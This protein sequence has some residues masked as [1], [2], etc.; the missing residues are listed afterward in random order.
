M[1]KW[2]KEILENLKGNESTIVDIYRNPKSSYANITM[3]NGHKAQVYK[4]QLIKARV[5]IGDTVIYDLEKAVMSH[6]E[7][8]SFNTNNFK[9]IKMKGEGKAIGALRGIRLEQLAFFDI[10][11]SREHLKL[12]KSKHEQEFNLFQ[13]KIR[14]WPDI[15]SEDTNTVK[16]LYEE[17]ANFF[18]EFSKLVCISM[19]ILDKEQNLKVVSLF[20][21]DEKSILEDLATKLE[22]MHKS[23][24]KYMLAGYSINSFDIP[25]LMQR[26]IYNGLPV[27]EMLDT[28]DKKPWEIDSVDAAQLI[29]GTF[30]YHTPMDLVCHRMGLKSPKE[31]GNGQDVPKLVDGGEWSRLAE[32]CEGDV[33]A[34]YNVVRKL[35]GLEASYDFNSNLN[36]FFFDEKEEE[37]DEG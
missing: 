36:E 15:D 1:S 17:K 28:S 11:T 4:K 37:E 6:P 31:L 14:N 33:V 30:R 26:Y 23:T 24:R 3:S 35:M 2:N 12:V 21:E 32:Y 18:P 8:E 22:A 10:E 29:K 25:Y 7:K 20:G 27:P 5:D 9:N 16:R 19:G 13:T 34:S